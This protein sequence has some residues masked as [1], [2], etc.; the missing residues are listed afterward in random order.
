M[1]NRLFEAGNLRTC[2]YS[3]VCRF[4][5]FCLELAMRWT[6]LRCCVMY[7]GGQ[8][9]TTTTLTFQR[10]K[11]NI[12]KIFQQTFNVWI[13]LFDR[14]EWSNEHPW[15]SPSEFRNVLSAMAR[16]VP[17]KPA[18]FK[19]EWLDAKAFVSWSKKAAIKR[20]NHHELKTQN[21][22]LNERRKLIW[23]WNDCEI[24]TSV[25]SDRDVRRQAAC[26]SHTTQH[27]PSWKAFR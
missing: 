8:L 23:I 25:Q 15:D 22:K 14:L 5:L 18:E 21:E 6:K 16:I 7:V 3:C 24:A 9:T 19:V 13:L 17:D 12:L 1:A 26:W 20:V 27:Q 10:L 4:V 2:H 11:A